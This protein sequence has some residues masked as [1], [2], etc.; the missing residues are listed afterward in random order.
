MESVAAMPAERARKLVGA[1]AA[2]IYGI[3]AQYGQRSSS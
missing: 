3:E 2:R 1:N